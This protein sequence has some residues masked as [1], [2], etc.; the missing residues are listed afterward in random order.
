MHT[1]MLPP[2]AG[3]VFA[4]VPPQ[5]RMPACSLHACRVLSLLAIPDAQER[6]KEALCILALQFRGST[7]ASLWKLLPSRASLP[8]AEATHRSAAPGL[9]AETCTAAA[10][11]AAA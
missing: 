9:W 3:H 2:V 7:P 6:Q 8:W 11:G 1:P 10:A 4:R 5:V